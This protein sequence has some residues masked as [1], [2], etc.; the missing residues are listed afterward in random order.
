MSLFLSVSTLGQEVELQGKYS[1]GFLGAETIE[2]IGN[3]SF[4]FD[5]FYCTYGVHGKGRCDIINNNLYLY[6]EK[7]RTKKADLLNRS[8]IVKTP[9]NDSVLKIKITVLDSYQI[10]IPYSIIIVE[11]E[12]SV[13]MK[14]TTDTTGQAIA[15]I[16]NFTTQFILRFSGVGFE[17]RYLKLDGG[18]NYDIELLLQNLS[19]NYKEYNNGEILVYEIQELNKEFILMRPL[20]SFDKFRK[21]NRVSIQ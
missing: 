19:L 2:F 17:P 20:N 13:V 9:T 10:P 15:Q 11:R 5:G 18:F 3:D 21:Y 1:A 16:K 4:R 12:G 7:N 8:T 6:F 14:M